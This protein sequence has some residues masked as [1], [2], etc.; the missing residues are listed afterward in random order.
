MNRFRK[1]IQ[2]KR[3]ND[4]KKGF[5]LL[6]F[7]KNYLPLKKRRMY[8]QKDPYKIAPSFF[9]Y[10]KEDLGPYSYRST[11]KVRCVHVI[12]IFLFYLSVIWQLFSLNNLMD[13]TLL[14]NYGGNTIG[15]NSDLEPVRNSTGGCDNYWDCNLDF[16]ETLNSSVDVN[17]ICFQPFLS[18]GYCWKE[19]YPDMNKI[20]GILN[21]DYKETGLVVLFGALSLFTTILE[22]IALLY[23]FFS[24]QYYKQNDYTSIE[25]PFERRFKYTDIGVSIIIVV[26][27]CL[28]IITSIIW[29]VFLFDFQRGYKQQS[30]DSPDF[31]L[32]IVVYLLFLIVFICQFILYTCR[33]LICRVNLLTR[34]KRVLF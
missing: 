9:S 5:F 6:F 15:M 24:V 13:S 12:F 28:L 33:S 32:S 8:D 20:F 11:I 19:P 22:I 7:K 4:F 25:N 16:C 29:I 18:E 10:R 14:V 30:F 31:V 17:W 21:R 2:C 3:S 23:R 27:R 34:I 26:N 1:K